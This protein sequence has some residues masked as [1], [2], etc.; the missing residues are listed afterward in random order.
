MV[1]INDVITYFETRYPESIRDLS[2]D[3]KNTGLLHGSR[4][5]ILS[6]IVLSLECSIEAIEH[7][8]SQNANLIICHHTPFFRPIFK[9]DESDYRVRVL[10]L[11]IQHDIAVYCSHTA[12]D[13][14]KVDYNVS[15]FL[16]QTFKFDLIKPFEQDE[17]GYGLGAICNV[18]ISQQELIYQLESIVGSIRT[19]QIE[20][21]Q[22]KK[23]AIVGGAGE[24][25][26]VLAKSMGCDALLTGDVTFHTA[27]DAMRENFLIIDIGHEAEE[28]AL[29]HLID[30]LGEK[31]PVSPVS[32]FKQ[33]ARILQ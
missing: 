16:A 19:N 9:Y 14:A 15:G 13:R 8:V 33:K 17:N 29:M 2:Y 21:E 24:S 26:W 7:A 10:K 5:T 20:K 25:F 27:Q 1:T 11:L 6:G 28:L 22:I 12:L 23:L 4:K 32:F 18:T 30:W 31:F 3:E